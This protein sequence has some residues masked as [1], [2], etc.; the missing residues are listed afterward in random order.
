MKTI[1]VSFGDGYDIIVGD[2]II[3]TLGKSARA[4]ADTKDASKAL[5][6]S[7]SSVSDACLSEVSMSL[8]LAGY[9]VSTYAIRPIEVVRRLNTVS[10]VCS[11]AAKAGFK[12]GDF[13]VALGDITACDIAGMAAGLFLC[14]SPLITV[15]TTTLAQIARTVGNCHNVD[16]PEEQRVLG[17]RWLPSL[18][19]CDTALLAGQ[20]KRNAASGIAEII[21]MG[22]VVS[23]KLIDELDGA[24]GDMEKLIVRAI[25]TRIKLIGKDDRVSIH[26]SLLHFGSLMSHAIEEVSGYSFD[27]GEAIAVGMVITCAAGERAGITQVG[28][29]EKLE[30]ILKKYGLPTTSNIPAERLIRTV[31]QDRYITGSTMSLPMIK[32]IGDGFM[33]RMNVVELRN[34]FISSLPD[35][36]K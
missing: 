19:L 16:L 6:V 25:T 24:A 14:G 5:I 33:H 18:A 29:T 10:E 32:S 22:C 21:R 35:W 27:H 20:T 3:K 13:F 15:P 9:T 2:G 28:T 17:V 11:E 4:L 34:F 12:R 8:K 31:A 30:Q 7:D 26:K 1:R 36:A 23:D